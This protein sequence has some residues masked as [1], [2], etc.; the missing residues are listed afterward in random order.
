MLYFTSEKMD[1]ALIG[2]LLIREGLIDKDKIEKALIIQKKQP[3]YL[4]YILVKNNFLPLKQFQKFLNTFD[5]EE[6]L[7]LLQLNISKDTIQKL[8]PKIAWFYFACPLAE[9]D[10][11]VIMAFPYL[12]EDNLLNSISQLISKRIKPIIFSR[13]NLYKALSKYYPLEPDKG[14]ILPIES[15]YGKFIVIDEKENIKPK[16]IAHLQLQ[17]SASEWLRSL[18]ANA[19]KGHSKKIRIFKQKEQCIVEYD[20]KDRPLF[21]LPISVYNRIQRLLTALAATYTAFKLP[22]RGFIKLIIKDKLLY[23]IVDSNPDVQGFNFRLEIFNE[24]ILNLHYS[25]I[26]KNYPEAT[27]L[28]EE[29]FSKPQGLLIIATPPGLDRIYS[30]Y[31]IIHHLKKDRDYVFIEDTISYPIKDVDQ[32][33]L[34]TYDLEMLDSLFNK[35]LVSKYDVIVI[36]SAMQKRIM[37]FAFLASTH[38][39]TIALMHSFDGAKAIEWLIKMGFKS[40]IKAGVLKGIIFFRLLNKVCPTCR[41]KFSLSDYIGYSS[42]E[43]E[44]FY[45]NSGCSFCQD[46]LTSEKFIL[47]ESIPIR[48]DIISILLTKDNA[49]SIKIAL[50]DLNIKLLGEK[51]LELASK[52][53]VDAQEVL[54]LLK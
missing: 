26:E 29:F 24:N 52:G 15:E 10:D 4:G 27:G 32:I 13:K 34:A 1:K 36:A 46:P 54:S 37:D 25:S 19:I 33:E 9:K 30:I 51:A 5:I 47:V 18:L 38:R 48:E 3:N 14:T 22:Q 40:P 11:E 44:E 42:S 20:K 43:E 31:P 35:I 6:E 8:S 23:L 17:D 7:K 39:K 50:K 16:S 53:I 41:I 45:T 21:P 49:E 12:P 2:E 28:L